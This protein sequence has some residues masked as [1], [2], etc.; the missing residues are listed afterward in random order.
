MAAA[1]FSSA[2]PLLCAVGMIANVVFIAKMPKLG[3]PPH[4]HYYKVAV[5]GTIVGVVV[6]SVAMFVLPNR[7]GE[8][9]SFFYVIHHPALVWPVWMGAIAMA[10][11]RW[12][13]AK[14]N[15]CVANAFDNYQR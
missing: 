1:F 7:V 2:S 4:T 15:G 13:N 12:D 8:E 3:I 5:A 6:I 14:K 10:Y 11:W 9:F